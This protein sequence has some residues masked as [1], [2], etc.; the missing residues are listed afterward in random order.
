MDQIQNDAT[1]GSSGGGSIPDI[2]SVAIDTLEERSMRIDQLRR[3][4][5]EGNYQVTG[6]AVADA[7]LR[8]FSRDA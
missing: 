7:I 4:I 1:D 6:E 2:W 5:A 8:F 3:E